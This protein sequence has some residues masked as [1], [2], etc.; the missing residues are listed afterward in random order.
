MIFV[1]DFFPSF[2]FFSFSF[3]LFLQ[4]IQGREEGGRKLLKNS[5]F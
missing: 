1:D 5:L 3:L 2:L 4:G